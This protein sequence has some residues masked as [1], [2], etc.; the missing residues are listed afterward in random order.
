M[1]K[2]NSDKNIRI[3]S[4]YGNRTLDERRDVRI[5]DAYKNKTNLRE[6]TTADRAVQAYKAAGEIGIHDIE[7]ELGDMSYN[8]GKRGRPRKIRN[9]ANSGGGGSASE[10]KEEGCAIM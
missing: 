2:L 10:K 7:R 9:M 8:D 1:K 3:K 5:V 4:S 6:R